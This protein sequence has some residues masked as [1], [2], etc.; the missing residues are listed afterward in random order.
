MPFEIQALVSIDDW[1]HQ[2]ASL[3]SRLVS[4]PSSRSHGRKSGGASPAVDPPGGEAASGGIVITALMGRLSASLSA[5]QLAAA[6][7]AVSNTASEM[8]ARLSAAHCG[9]TSSPES[10]A[11]TSRAN[12]TVS[13]ELAEAC[14]VA[15]SDKRADLQLADSPYF[16]APSGGPVQV[17]VGAPCIRLSLIDAAHAETA[18]R[19]IHASMISPLAWG[20]PNLG[21]YMPLTDVQVG[22]WTQPEAVRLVSR[23]GAPLPTPRAALHRD[24]ISAGEP[25]LGTVISPGQ[26]VL[27]TLHEIQ[28]EIKLPARDPSLHAEDRQEPAMP[29]LQIFVAVAGAA[30]KPILRLEEYAA[31]SLLRAAIQRPLMVQ[32]QQ[33]SGQ[34]EEAARALHLQVALSSLEAHVLGPEHLLASRQTLDGCMC[35][36][37]ANIALSLEQQN[38]QVCFLTQ[39]PRQSVLTE[40]PLIMTALL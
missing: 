3:S 35:L 34:D 4:W 31:L 30:F 33:S 39:Q 23:L 15:V 28:M 17:L 13:A 6:L 2:T 37:A 20:S 40:K 7:C 14:L 25:E 8:K 27:L 12:F 29:P 38:C 16:S 11:D 24:D 5:E 22:T 32:N 1:S 18:G 10:T 21:I 26:A 36:K 19:G 9:Y